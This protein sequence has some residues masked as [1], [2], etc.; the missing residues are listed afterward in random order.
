MIGEKFTRHGMKYMQTKRW[1][2]LILTIAIVA[3]LGSALLMGDQLEVLPGIY[4]QVSYHN[5]AI[6]L[7]SGHGFT[8]GQ[9]WWPA[10]PAG[11]PTAQWSYLYTFYLVVLYSIFGVH[12]LVARVI[13]A[14]VTGLL[15]PW[16]AYRL[17]GKVFGASPGSSWGGSDGAPLGNRDG[18]LGGRSAIGLLAAGWVAVYGYFVYYS[19]ALMTEMFYTTGILAIL[20]I[21]LKIADCLKEGRTVAKR[22]WLW[23]GVLAGVTAMLRQ[24]ALLFVPFMFLWLLWAGLGRE[25]FWKATWNVARGGLLSAIVMLVMIL[26]VTLWNY[27]QFNRF[28]LLNTNAG[29]AFFWANHPVEGYVFKSLY[30]SDMPTYQQVIPQDL[31]GLNEAALDQALLRLGIGFVLADPL[32]YASL[33]ITRF[34]AFFEFWPSGDSSLVSNI[35]RVLSFGLALPFMFLGIILWIFAHL[36]QPRFWSNLR[37]VFRAPGSLLVL[38]ILCNS[39]IYLLSWA[40]IRYR[41]PQD[42]VGLIF[43]AFGAI[44]LIDRILIKKKNVTPFLT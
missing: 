13:Q 36:H 3:R 11:Q 17:A 15:M 10:T 18:A 23:L 2:I 22:D 5:L 26:P 21:G 44:W 33:T 14:V 39:G 38:F 9:E 34:P 28:V 12:P 32:R 29:S 30:T 25:R 40:M 19:G 27:H 37:E 35:T 6:R 41:L 42:S 20:D 43:A 7:L 4:D 31:R 1:L 16:L 8:F 24:V